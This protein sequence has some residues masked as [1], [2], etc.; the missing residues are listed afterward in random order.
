MQSGTGFYSDEI[1]ARQGTPWDL[2]TGFFGL[3]NADEAV[4]EITFTGEAHDIDFSLSF[5]AGTA[6]QP[7]GAPPAKLFEYNQADSGITQTESS[8]AME[9]D[10]DFVVVWTQLE[11]RTSDAFGYPALFGSGNQSIFYR[12]FDEDTDT[13][14]P[15]VTDLISS[16]GERVDN[17]EIISDVNG[18]RYIVVPFSE[19]L[20]AGDPATNPDSVLNPENFVL[21]QAGV[22]I[23]FGVINVEF[24]MNKAADLSGK[25]DG[26]GGI[27]ETSPVPTNKWEAV[28]TLDA[29]G[30]ASANEV[31][32][33][34]GVFRIEGRAPQPANLISGLRDKAGNALGY[35]G[36]FQAGRDLG[37]TFIVDLGNPDPPVGGVLNGRT[38]PESP[39]AVAMD[40]DGDH[41]VTWTVNLGGQDRVYAQVYDANGFPI[42]SAPLPFEVTA[43]LSE[44]AQDEQRFSTVAVDADG[45]FIVSWTNIR[46]GE[47]DVY[48]R[49]YNANGSAKGAPF[50]VNLYAENVQ[51]WSDVAMDTDGDTVVVWASYGQEEAT[52][53]LGYGYGVYARRYDSQG[54]PLGAEFR[55][56]VT[57]TGHQQYPSVAM[58]TRGDFMVAWTSDQGGAGDD[59]IARAF[60]ADGSPMPLELHLQSATEP[61][62]Y[63]GPFGG[64]IRVNQTT[65]GNQRYPDI[66]VDLSGDNYAITWSSS[67]QD[68][69]GWGINARVLTRVQPSQF[70]GFFPDTELGFY[71]LLGASDELDVNT[72]TTGDQKFSSVSMD[73]HG[74]FVVGW[75]GV[76][77]QLGQEDNSGVFYQRYFYG[78]VTGTAV[79]DNNGNPVIDPITGNPLVILNTGVA[80]QGS[81]VR[82]NRVT[83]GKQWLPS[84]A[85]DGEGNFVL[86]WTGDVPAGS[87][88]GP[89]Q[90]YRALSKDRLLMADDDGP[91]VTD[92][93]LPNASLTHDQRR[94]FQ[95]DVLQNDALD[96]LVVV[97]GENLSKRDEELISESVLNIDNWVIEHN[98]TEIQGGIESV[99]FGWN[100]ASRK[101]EAVLNFDG[102]GSGIPGSPQLAPGDYSILI[103]E[104]ITDGVLSSGNPL[105]TDFD[106]IP[107]TN[108]ADTQIEGFRFQFYV[109]NTPRFGQEFR[110]NETTS[111]VQTASERL[112]TGMGAEEST[113]SMAMDHDGDFVVV[114]TSYGQ[115]DP[116]DPTGGG[117]YYR[118]F[119]RNDNP[120]TP[121][122]RVNTTTAGHQR[123][124]SVAMDADGDFVVVWESETTK[125][126][127]AN[128]DGS[129]DVYGQR[130]NSVGTPVGGEFRVNTETI[131]DQTDP[132]V[133]MD[134]YG[135]FVVV[136]VAS[137]LPLGW[138]ND[139]RGQVYD[140]AG[141]PVGGEIL[142]NDVDSPGTGGKQSNPA[143]GM[144]ADGDFVVAWDQRVQQVNEID[145]NTMVLARMFDR[146]GNPQTN[147]NDPFRT[148][149]AVPPND[150]SF[151]VNTDVTLAAPEGGNF[152]G[153]GPHAEHQ[154]WVNVI[155]PSDIRSAARNAQV[156][157]DPDGNFIIIWEAF[158]DNDVDDDPTE[159]DDDVG[160]SDPNDWPDSYGIYFHR[161]A[162]DGT[163]LS[164]GDYAAN[165]VITTFPGGEDPNF[166]YSQVNPTVA[167]DADG[168]FAVAWNGNGAEPPPI[169]DPA[170]WLLGSHDS[171]GI[172]V[173]QFAGSGPTPR[174]PQR[175]VNRTTAGAQQFPTLAMQPDGDMLVV[176]SGAGVGDHSGLF[177]RRYNEPLDT[178]GPMATELRAMDG[179]LIAG[180]VQVP[181]Q[182][183]QIAVVF[184]ERM[185]VSGDGS[186]ID[187]KNWILTDAN[188]TVLKNRISNIQFRLNPLSNKWEAVITF[189]G[190]GLASGYYELTAG[191][192]LKDVVGNQLRHT[193]RLQG[194][195]S[196]GLEGAYSE[197]LRRTTFGFVVGASYVPGPGVEFLVN[198]SPAFEQ[199]LGKVYETGSAQEESTRSL[200]V[201]HDGDFIVTWTSYGQDDGSD[202][203]GAGVFMRMF[204]RDNRP[205][206]DEIQVNTTVAGNQWNSA[207]AI[208]AD[209]E[210]VVVWQ[211]DG[212]D[213]DGSSGIYARYFSSI[214]EPLT[215]EFRVN[216]DWVGPQFNPSVAMDEIG[217]FVV[218]W[219]TSGQPF[220]FFNNVKGKLYD[221][222]ANP[223]TL[224]FRVNTVDIPG[225]GGTGGGVTSIEL[226][227]SVEMAPDG[228]FVVAWERI[229]GQD[230][231]IIENSH[232]YARMFDETGTAR[233]P[234]GAASNAE[235]RVNVSLANF[236]SWA[237]HN[238][239]LDAIG[240]GS[241]QDPFIDRVW[242]AR[243]PQISMD[244]NGNFIVIWEGFQDNDWIND[245]TD[246]PES[247][248]IY[249]HIYA[250]DGG[251]PF[252]FDFGANLVVTSPLGLGPLW[253]GSLF[254]GH[255]VN[256]SIAMDAD[257]DLAIVWNGNGVTTYVAPADIA[258]HDSTGVFRTDYLA[259]YFEGPSVSPGILY[260]MERV[261]R[262]GYGVQQFPSIGMERDGD[263]VV[264]WQGYGAGDAHGIFARRYDEPTDT[265]GP[266]ATEL[267]A[268][269]GSLVGGP[270]SLTFPEVDAQQYIVV[271]LDE[272]MWLTGDDSVENVE[273]WLLSNADGALGGAIVRVQF[274]LNK[275]SEL[276]G[277]IDPLTGELYG[278]N[279]K[280]T[281]KFEAVITLDG[282]LD[283]ADIQPLPGGE[284][285]LTAFAPRYDDPTTLTIDETQSGLRDAVGN[286]LRHTGFLPGGGNIVFQ[287]SVT[288]S[289]DPGSGN[290]GG[291][292]FSI[293]NGRTYPESPGAVAVDA[294]GD[295]VVVL[296][297]TDTNTGLDRV[298]VQMFDADGKP[299]ATRPGLFQVT[300]PNDF[301]DF[302]GDDQRFATV[303]ADADGDF[304]V[305]WAN[306]RGSE[307][308][309]YARRF[310][311]DG[312][313]MGP[314][315][316]VNTYTANV[317]TWPNVAMDTDGD[318]VV[319][320]SS[321]AQETNGQLGTGY[322]VYAR[323]Y[324]S[325][326]YPLA[327]EF[328]VN[329]T[330]AGNQQ[331]SNVAL[332]DDGTTIIVWASDQ[333]GIGDDI[334]GRVY[335]SDGAPWV[336][337]LGG[338]FPI[339]N[340]VS[341]GN[342]RYPD[343]DV[344]MGNKFV[345]TWS[346][347]DGSGSGVFAQAYDLVLLQEELTQ[348]TQPVVPY[349]QAT[350]VPILDGVTTRSQLT[351]PDSYTVADVNIT[352]NITHDDPDEL[353]ILLMSP[354][355][356]QIR[357]FAQS[358]SSAAN[359]FINTRFDD[360]PIADPNNPGGSI[361]PPFI[362]NTT[363]P[364]FTGVF[365][366]LEPLSAFIG[367]NV[368]GTWEL[369]IFDEDRGFQPAAQLV[370]WT[371]NVTRV[372]AR[373]GEIR[374]NQTV[375]GDQ[376]YSSVAMDAQGKFVVTWSGYGNQ[377]KSDGTGQD[378]SS[379]V[380]YQHFDALA[381]KLNNAQETRANRQKK[382]RQW[383]PSVQN[384]ADGGFVIV[385]TGAVLDQNG[386]VI[387]GVTDVFRFV[388]PA[389]G[390]TAGPLVT[391]VLMAGPGRTRVLDGDVLAPSTPITQLVVTFSEAL[392]KRLGIT[393]PLPDLFDADDPGLDSVLNPANWMLERNGTEILGGVKN[394]T[395][396][397]NLTTRKYEAVV[398]LDGNG[399]SNDASGSS[400]TPLPDG[401]YVLT[402]VDFITDAYSFRAGD[403]FFDGNRLD[404]DFDGLPGTSAFVSSQPGFSLGFVVAN[405][406]QVGGEFRINAEDTKRFEQRISA[407]YGIGQARE[408]STQSVA[409]DHD[410]D[411]V[412]VWTSYGQDDPSDASGAGVY[413]RM[414]DRNN[415][416][417]TEETLVNT[418]TVGDQRNA[419]VAMDA[420]GE[421]VITWESENQ[422]PDGSWGIFARRYNSVGQPMVSD[423]NND[424]KIT[425]L[426]NAFPFRV[427]TNITGHQLNPAVAMDDFGNFAIVWATAGQDFSF[428]ND[429]HG[430]AYS[431][432]GIRQGLE[433]LANTNN[434][435]GTNPPPAGSFEINP[436]VAMSGPASNFVVAWEV[437]TA[438]QNGAVLDSVIAARLF[439][440]GGTPTADP[441]GTPLPEFQAD[442]AVGTGGSDID[443]VARNPQLVV[444]DRG[445]FIVVWEASSGNLVDGYSVFYRQFDA[446]AN[447]GA[448]AQVNMGQFVDHQVNP[449]VGIDAD[450][451]FAVVWNGNGGQPDPLA[452]GNV[453]LWGDLDSRGVF[454]RQY[455]ASAPGVAPQPVTV[456]SRVNRTVVGAQE[457][458]T[459]GVEPDGDRI[460]V[461][462]GR[463]IGDPHGIF[464]RRYDEPTDTAGPRATELRTADGILLLPGSDVE[465]PQH[466]VVVFDENMWLLD[467]DSVENV[468]NWVLRRDGV[469]FEDAI[470]LIRFGLNKSY[471]LGLAGAK[472][473]NKWEAVI[474]FDG[475]PDEPGLSALPAGEY[476]LTA[477]HP[478]QDNPATAIDE[479]QSGLRDAVGNP[480][481]STGFLPGGADQQFRFD[482]IRG[483]GVDDPIDD[484]GNGGGNGTPANGRTHAETPGAVA[485]DSDGDH[486]IT[487]TAEDPAT[488]RDRVYARMFQGDGGVPYG[489]AVGP[490]F[491]VTLDGFP[492]DAQR[493][494][495]VA[496]DA[497][498]DF[499]ITWTNY[500][501]GDA[502]IYAQRFNAAGARLGT[503]FR[504]NTY[505]V[506]STATQSNQK[507]SD[508]AMDVDGDFIITWSSYSQEDRGQLGFG[509]GVYARRYDSFGQP[510]APE[511]LVNVTTEGNQQFSKVA[512]DAVGGFAL[513]WVS[514]QNGVG[515]DIV[516]RSYWPDGSPQPTGIGSGYLYGEIVANDTTDGNQTFPDISMSLDGRSFVV[517]W[518]G[519]DSSGD[520][521]YGRQFG[522]EIVPNT[523]P[524]A[525]ANA[526]LPIAGLFIPHQTNPPI[527]FAGLAPP[528][529]ST[530]V[531]TDNFVIDDLDV[532]INIQHP[533][534]SDLIISLTSPAGTTVVLVDREPENPAGNFITGANFDGTI[535]DDEA[536]LPIDRDPTPRPPYTGRFQP[537]PGLL[538]AFDGQ[539]SQGTWTL[540]IQ[541][542]RPGPWTPEDNPLFPNL[543]ELAYL[544]GWSIDAGIRFRASSEFRV[545]TKVQGDQTYPSVAVGD[546]GDFVITWSGRDDELLPGE[547]PLKRDLSGHAVFLQR[548]DAGTSPIGGQ[549]RIN[550]ITA[551]NQWM[552]SI[553]ADA[554]G[555]TVIVWT[556]PM[557]DSN[558]NVIPNA[559]GIYRFLSKSMISRPDDLGP[560]VTDVFTVDGERIFNG[561][562]ISLNSGSLLSGLKL[563]VSENLSVRD[564]ASGLDSVLNPENWILKRN[565]TVLPGGVHNVAF[566]GV[567]SASRKFEIT[568][569]FDGDALADG[570]NPL[571]PGNYELTIR[572]NVQ[573]LYR[574]D[575]VDDE[576][577][578]FLG[579]SL[580]GD[581]DGI[582]GTRLN[583]SGEDGLLFTFA[584]TSG[585]SFGAE[586]L[587]N[588]TTAYEQRFS[589]SMGTGLGLEESTRSLAMDRDGDFA[590]AWTSYGQDHA[591]DPIGA[592]V[593][594][595]VFDRK[596]QPLF[597]ND[598][599][600]NTF[601]AGDQR[602]ASV[603][604][605][606]DGDFV[607]VWESEG[608]DAD[609]SWGIYGQR[610]DATGFP[611]GSEFRVHSNTTN[612]QL[613]P[614]V[615]MDLEG[616]F[617]VVWATKGQSYSFGN[618]VHAQRFD[619]LGQ[620]L[621]SE[622]RVN[623]T[624]I[625]GTNLL[626]G[627]IELNP[628][629][630]M[631][632]AGNFVVAWD[633]VIVQVNGS[634]T[635]E[636]V[637]ARL[638]DAQGIPNA[639]TPNEFP[640]N[641]GTAFVGDPQHTPVP[642]SGGNPTEHQARNPQ[643][644][645]D[646]SG[647]FIIAWEAFEDNDVDP[648]QGADSYGVYFRRFNADGTPEMAVDHQANLVITTAT[649]TVPD[650]VIN[651]DKFAFGQV[652]PSVAMDADG[653]YSLVW[654]GNG[655]VPH[656]L[657]PDTQD[658]TNADLDGVWIRSFHA[659]DLQ[660]TPEFVSV[661]TRVN[662]T[663]D[664]IQQFPSIAMEPDGD[665][666]VV[667]SGTGVGD[668][669][670]IF[671]RR[672]DEPTDT[673]G[674]RVSDLMTPWRNRI[675]NGSQVTDP[676]QVI[677]VAF[678]EEMM[679]S[680]PNSVTNPANYALLKDGTAVVGIIK[681]I[682]FGLNMSYLEGWSSRQS[683]K[684]EAV[685]II[686]GNGAAAGEPVL[687]QGDYE[688][689]VRNSVRDKAG[690]PLAS[691]WLLPNGANFSRRF[692]LIAAGGAESRVNTG[693]GDAYVES[694]QTVATD[695]DGDY[696]TVWVNRTAGEQGVWARMYKTAWHEVNGQPLSTI[697]PG[698]PFKV[699]GSESAQ[700]AAVATDADGDFVVTW[701]QENSVTGFDVYGQRYD[702]T[703]A[704]L[705]GRFLVNSE[706]EGT[707][708]S[709]AVAMDENGDFV[710]TWQSFDQ[711]GDGWGIYAQRY[712]PAGVPLGGR[713]E[714]QVLNLKGN[715]RGAFAL[716]WDG[717]TTGDIQL[718]ASP[719]GSEETIRQELATIGAEVEVV[720]IS[721]TEVSIR[722]VG[723]DGARNQLPI[724]VA[725]QPT[726][727]AAGSYLAMTT[728]IE[729]SSGEFLVNEATDNN[730]MHPAIAMDASGNFVI[731]WSGYGQDGDAVDQ[732]NVYAR[733][734][735][736]NESIRGATHVPNEEQLAGINLMEGAIFQPVILGPMAPNNY[737]LPDGAG[738]DGVVMVN[739][740]GVFN[741][742]GT[743]LDTGIHI[744][745]A[746][747]VV[748][749]PIFGTA[750]PPALVSV[751]FNMPSGPVTIQAS[752]VF[753]HPDY[754]ASV[755]F[756]GDIAVITLAEAAPVNAERF[757]IYRETDEVGK[758]SDHYGFGMT[759]QGDLGMLF[760][761]GQRR[762][763][764]NRYEATGELF[765]TSNALLFYDFDN[766]MAQFDAFGQVFG[767]HDLGL[768]LREVNVAPGDS[769]GPSMIDGK[770]AGIHTAILTLGGPEDFTS[771]L[772]ASFG[773]F[774]MDT[775]VS[776]YADWI[777]SV[778]SF[779]P[780][781]LVNQTT[782]NNQA[783]S[784][785]AMDAEGD[786]VITWTSYGQDGVGTGYGG[787]VNGENGVFAR[788]YSGSA[789]LGNEF[790]VNTYG[791]GDQ[792]MSRV[793]M[794]ADGDFVIAW[795]SDGQDGDAWGIYS[796]RFARNQRA[797]E[798]PLLDAQGLPVL[799][800][801]G[802]PIMVL[803]DVFLGP[804][805]RIGG[806]LLIN[807]TTR[808]NQESA[809]IA[810]DDTGNFV[811]VWSGQ[812]E[813]PGE[814]DEQGVFQR[815]FEQPEDNAGT[816]VTDVFNVITEGNQTKLGQLIE[817]PV[818]DETVSQFV[819]AFSEN[820]SI[821][822]GENGFQSVIDPFNW[823]L[824]KDGD[825]LTGG[826]AS[827]EFGLNRASV[828]GLG[829]VSGKFEA[830]I[831]FDGDLAVSGRQPL[832]AGSYQLVAQDAIEDL[833]ENL[834][835]GD[836]DGNAGGGYSFSFSVF[837]GLPSP[838]GP[839]GPGNPGP[840]DT[841]RRVNS[842]FT[843]NQAT[844]AVASNAD[845]DYVAVWASDII[846][847]PLNPA[848]QTPVAT[849]IL[850]QRYNRFG[851]REGQEFIVASF[852]SDR[853]V[854]PDVAMDRFG[855]FV[856]T[857]SGQGEDDNVGV[858]ARV[859]DAAG[860][861]LAKQFRVNQSTK[862]D[863]DAPSVAMDANGDFIVTWSSYGQDGPYDSIFARRYNN[864]G[865]ALSGEF[866]V[867]TRLNNHKED[868]DVAADVNGN[869]VVVWAAMGQDESDLGVFGRRFNSAGN[870]LGGEFRINSQG[871]DVQY[872]PQVAMYSDGSF[873]V[874]W[875]SFLQDGSGWGVYARRYGS[876]GAS[877]GNEFR[878]NQTTALAQHQ[879]AVST[880]D[881]GKFAITWSSLS[882]EPDATEDYG[883]YARIFNAN[884]S[885]YVD[886]RTQKPLG[887]FRVNANIE[888]DQTQPAVAMDADGD[889][890]VVWAG[891]DVDDDGIYHRIVA[892]NPST[893]QQD[894]AT[895]AGMGG[896]TGRFLLASP[897]GIG[898]LAF[899]GTAG[900]DLFEVAP[901]STAGSWV[902]KVNGVVQT[903]PETTGAIRFDG[904]GGTDTVL[905]TGTAADETVDLSPHAVTAAS[906]GFSVSATNVE[907]VTVDGRGGN[908]TININDSAGDDTLVARVGEITI[909][910][911]ATYSHQALG[912]ETMY[913]YSSGNAGDTAQLYDSDG[914]DTFISKEK[915]STLEGP[916]FYHRVKGYPNI[917][918]Y[919]SG[920]GV[921]EA[922]LYDTAGGDR[923][924]GYPTYAR[925]FKGSYVHR[926]KFFES[927]VVYA[928]AGDGDDARFFDSKENDLF[929]AGN[930]SARFSSA[931]AGF[932]ITV[933]SFD[934]VLA[935]SRT[936]GK[937]TALFQGSPNRDV[938]TAKAHKS[939][940]TGD[941][942]EYTV[943]N[944]E[945]VRATA[946]TPNVGGALDVAK[947]YD[948]FGDDHFVAD[949]ESATVYKN[950]DVLY[951]AIA[952]DIVKARRYNG[953]ND[954]KDTTA[955]YAYDLEFENWPD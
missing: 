354:S 440:A 891:P 825:L 813:V 383:L 669:H 249:F 52:G 945:T 28:L 942:S 819:I 276:A 314:V 567:E 540:E 242:V 360:G 4:F 423:V 38:H 507:W 761:D 539:P 175:L 733:Q 388:A 487:W 2:T 911:G 26:R 939:V 377:W 741:G 68:G 653:D 851:Q 544:K 233:I 583:G 143:V 860:N 509:Y 243:N 499:I 890:V 157:M 800:V 482:V 855:N 538:A 802:N 479:G 832:G 728:A 25:P 743:L 197:T 192:D 95:G 808:G 883:I 654:N 353:T 614:A 299:A 865:Q 951:E 6:T 46:D 232:I 67:A 308:D 925:L 774:A 608:Q 576:D 600:V 506:E 629:I 763:G 281:N 655:A 586:F 372:P 110:I 180:G 565:G 483:P 349:V 340:E 198:Q 527:P 776:I 40:A 13:A 869:F 332:K 627:S 141:R 698:Q 723:S 428:F 9:P 656:P 847:N 675:Q 307:Q 133:A 119:D 513:V 275:A 685:L 409:V 449:S 735:P 346:G 809:G 21:Y 885:D 687:P 676:L 530:I 495:S 101:Y 568:I 633:Q 375:E 514:D 783:F 719:F 475:N 319:T 290:G 22:E 295:Y 116:S 678:D 42:P 572:D 442:T 708:D 523:V 903:I 59:I 953:G 554:D 77:D 589:A 221:F 78:G 641:D 537:F 140:F 3:V 261:N 781:F 138:N 87:P 646:E 798:V 868:S 415:V 691:T 596:N 854:E 529:I 739:L 435:P 918:A 777:D 630:A 366:P 924:K 904:L 880:D 94:V 550:Y 673:A 886:P 265:A 598:R 203:D 301:P 438:Q 856:V 901:G 906:L 926:A 167:V 599:R 7:Q 863:Q 888:G 424:G 769:G 463:G 302:V 259:A 815:R 139:I 674:P 647:N 437:V 795:Q 200:A 160:G 146:F 642:A 834:L 844:P 711:D 812:G 238:P 818:L 317:Q 325:F 843:G 508:V 934:T 649:L 441:T 910:D 193:G 921:D 522:R 518:A 867:N 298:F 746:A 740:G 264:V 793:A 688:L 348:G 123:S 335:D 658:V 20:M 431:N 659:Q 244:D 406:P 881:A 75:S 213:F 191:A 80:P 784:S 229:D 312:E 864:R 644:A 159:P 322:G 296:T 85:Q 722:F 597:A 211:S 792:Q 734:F 500:L 577:A 99:T 297:A 859:F 194:S 173:R 771:G 631:D 876:S 720:A 142:I 294:D 385:W 412:A 660:T 118:M 182:L 846:F 120:L 548:Y 556:G 697:T 386:D 667:W 915:Y 414:Y 250:A 102:N 545:N 168:D 199:V 338:E 185:A 286:P 155:G 326:G 551:G 145:I 12:R 10:G 466:L 220:S 954:T 253:P 588:Q 65:N 816:R 416:P 929:E 587:V 226:N 235:F 390:D 356:R 389:S 397:K 107:G 419:A 949:G 150:S 131:R 48:A 223:M 712:N 923:L 471:S 680:G 420:D 668:R 176:W 266:L 183:Q 552:P 98:G 810:M 662:M 521:V 595:R 684:W 955:A 705:G 125:A 283:E 105:D 73:H 946:D 373:S 852:Q 562:V 533:R 874:T 152:T 258:D 279:P 494:A 112:G 817:E 14:G 610:F 352:L 363:N 591:G 670:G 905:I 90:V 410:G 256:P 952:F 714:V 408:E 364:P 311:A 639:I 459:I 304:V 461:W 887:E 216:T 66:A 519:P 799:D 546:A 566:S 324:D 481:Q 717:H 574:F 287:F 53:A 496:A 450:G 316:R 650:P 933:N 333:G 651:S 130:F 681:Q 839:G 787:G 573:D 109:T 559:T 672:Y 358:G 736:R 381:Q 873:V 830:V 811:I 303:A 896:Y 491:P 56:N 779:G 336:G 76:G 768:G 171:D 558:G 347:P 257:G 767:I 104:S 814:A 422:D 151:T 503:P 392:S 751:T 33:G 35:S 61:E 344:S 643:A 511:F 189:T 54:M 604:M 935:F 747:H 703:G 535:F 430:Q 184:D 531:F 272:S 547:D 760:T 889:F 245:P 71:S 163:P 858:F 515:T 837:G 445:G 51:K 928:T 828:A 24:G 323:K 916:G 726:A 732:T 801:N 100:P 842:I 648:L 617:V 476:T 426:D 689:I 271:T 602:N 838:G 188:G 330:T 754:D 444:D 357:L 165:Y 931:G 748:A 893:Y 43:G 474:S 230:T 93:L 718:G 467:D 789:P 706:T 555:N 282:D 772:D 289:V 637:V 368:S 616:N 913:A 478:V 246:T 908:D 791:Q 638:F 549:T 315:F 359:D 402:I 618:D 398:T 306:Y 96:Q 520:G 622:F 725:K 803:E 1:L 369:I 285:S 560:L 327:P 29:D 609:G 920:L 433:F 762:S 407:N 458:P 677:I 86:V 480:I 106:G 541:D 270:Q 399:L 81:E 39:G 652:N 878:V 692:N 218:V 664:G 255:Q 579:N 902:V 417:L 663:T 284:Y 162:S 231:S 313:P 274:G 943:R 716:R 343:V 456:Q 334:F 626:P 108:V 635:D 156:A 345:V 835:D 305:T 288:Q 166:A 490:L 606:A 129:W 770:I 455:H 601:T 525:A 263:S 174:N 936:G 5:A 612:D 262:T 365:S 707:Q 785:V 126:G 473:T 693:S 849:H 505:G 351:V 721:L 434:I 91:I 121:E 862:D 919:A 370:D 526:S 362:D 759:G 62:W 432:F 382:G 927:V 92:V 632:I 234:A 753:V 237:D 613:N 355:G 877:L 429:V 425:G 615:A 127:L 820:L 17:L 836:S 79:L 331:T 682:K 187:P 457:F 44:F 628:T 766:G 757:S 634:A 225:P 872:D 196:P 897:A 464:A 214:G 403:P 158:Q 657:D 215:G 620:K 510:L 882:Q 273:N 517:T 207:V 376:I 462:S 178:A 829:P 827:V 421:F 694:G 944:F 563:A 379:G 704:T 418:F 439:D 690:N 894:A 764:Q 149:N 404:G 582:P 788:R 454:I 683:N 69:S 822:G 248:G 206:T 50:Q 47:Y 27:Y 41:V 469:V 23:P 778:T 137:G 350:A 321:Y 8:I 341:A 300:D 447:P 460:V 254:A 30:A 875:S 590:V 745:T 947:L 686:D 823:E 710:I 45:D 16:T 752:E 269:D 895:G 205:L 501:N 222:N 224:E 542:A 436:A 666:L 528:V 780:E 702:A 758:V 72:T 111:Y 413:F 857:W 742:T 807:T 498:G 502:D 135:D 208:D 470:A 202:A 806:E 136:Y 619:Y 292:D 504:A 790:Q 516:A 179:T 488:G 744:V 730:Q 824:Y 805:G 124:A 177:A 34:N 575:P 378:D 247:Y 309:V 212:Q 821:E 866:K 786:F 339:N 492:A 401:Q 291:N 884:G 831:T 115:D 395:F 60:K 561:G 477:L 241:Q 700:Q 251:D 756:G 49:R 621:G 468:D 932:D 636:V 912:F 850:A 411:F 380:F 361:V 898:E 532:R 870:A 443:R 195:V 19:E 713:N 640:V 393:G 623:Q 342:Q 154:N 765:G 804:N 607:V 603:A 36:Y 524:R 571:G 930:G 267:R 37:R 497:D 280:P 797:T 453:N 278:L 451:D 922:R 427:N 750:L 144:D 252:A 715:P 699:T 128:A 937:D 580:D 581:F 201:D 578:Y 594:V 569:T 148:A 153:T 570:L 729:G 737:V 132:A 794:D 489:S 260:A 97:F 724:S 448:S 879:P 796:Q 337:P 661:Q 553:G 917:H 391:D 318:F 671:A 55:V 396:Q 114:W 113:R 82:A 775:R 465:G 400:T 907:E 543:P 485:V 170:P 611:L 679:Q 217:N 122:R 914:N 446:S 236:S 564:A 584:V 387:P 169:Y 329:I 58:D 938:L 845:G 31:R 486:I 709:P 405:G 84:I 239:K 593:Y 909:T 164:F 181:G 536:L 695:A 861:P 557:L 731:S 228:S 15:I 948:S 512:M 755:I 210:F 147:N 88:G 371:L 696:V 367:E 665:R 749:D 900:D 18:V 64:E 70:P 625:P 472:V 940:F 592:G 227:P 219:G 585:P 161:F 534:V 320:W 277:Q 89:T 941:G 103:R 11:R 374:V 310:R 209:G 63:M 701:S 840:Q 782:L 117:V 892:L 853:Q 826:I 727:G 645:M 605:D 848:G 624:T 190:S 452:P 738:Y 484:G 83:A 57:T 394:V 32:L 328:Q 172:F 134:D 186:V 773:E 871:N 240:Q 74:Q 268:A 384:S 899:T 950:L 493:F 833:F 293:D 841:D 204:D